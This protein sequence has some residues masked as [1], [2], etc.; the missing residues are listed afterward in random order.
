MKIGDFHRVPAPKHEREIL[1]VLVSGGD[2]M[3]LSCERVRAAQRASA[4]AAGRA[5]ADGLAAGIVPK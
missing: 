4:E 3:A 1:A 2:V 5:M